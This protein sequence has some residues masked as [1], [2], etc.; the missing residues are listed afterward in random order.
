MVIEKL[1]LSNFRN[2][3]DCE[4]EPSGEVNVFFGENG[5]GKTNLLEAVSLASVG[6]SFKA[7]K[8]EEMVKFGAELGRVIVVLDNQ[9][10]LEVMVTG[11]VVSGKKSSK[12]IFK[13]SGANKRRGNFVGNLKTV[14]F[15]PEDMEFMGG[16]PAF[17]R[18]MIDKVLMQMDGEYSRSLNSYG[19][20]LRR[21]NRL[22][23]MI[24]RGEETRYSLAFWDGML[25]KHGEIIFEKRLEFANFLNSL[26]KRSDLFSNLSFEYDQSAINRERLKQYE[27]QE[28]L[29]GHTLV[30]PHKDD[31][32]MFFKFYDKDGGS[33]NLSIYGSRGEQRMGVL[34][35]KM[36]EVYFLERNSSD[37]V[38]LLLDDVLSELDEKH[39]KEVLRLTLD[40]QVFLTTANKREVNRFKKARVFNL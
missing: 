19:Q 15:R 13:M 27:T 37:K 25:I 33:K 35:L 34:A 9:E 1:L 6:E 30:G 3:E 10:K 32:K 38:V 17:R 23:D 22:L 29:V 40:R 18:S 31:F 20:A 24:R 8:I 28:V 36:G 14:L 2:Y 39:R 5:V 4:F 7:Y 26:W 11:G 21:R 16:S 12:R